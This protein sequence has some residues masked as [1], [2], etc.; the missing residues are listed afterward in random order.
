M[1]KIITGLRRCGKSF[2]L[3]RLYHDHLLSRGVA[4]DHILE[5]SLEDLTNVDLLDPRALLAHIRTQVRDVEKYYILLDEIQLVENFEGLLNSLLH[6]RNVEVFVT[7]SNSRFLSSDIVTGFRGRGYEIRLHPFCYREFLQAGYA[8]E[9]EAWDDFVNYGGIPVVLTGDTPEEKMELLNQLFRQV[10]VKDIRERH[11]LRHPGEFD[12]LLDLLASSV[13][14]LT[15]PL[16]L[17]RTFQS[18][19]QK[20]ISDLTL[21]SYLDHL[22]D[23]FLV[24]HAQRYDLR[25]KRYINSPMKYYFEDVGL[26]NARLGFRQQ[27]ENHL[28]ENILFNEL[29]VRGCKVDVGVVPIREVV[30]GK[31]VETKLEIDFVAYR[32]SKKYYLQSAFEMPNGDKA[33]QENRPL[34]A[35]RDSFKKIIVVKDNISVRRDEYGIATIGIRKFLQDPES[36]EV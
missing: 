10:Y 32:G 24:S 5:Y 22:E 31:H 2:L 30:D 9:D 27:E 28:M 12:E 16:K 17:S 29:K 33:A 23:A 11:K 20:R 21:R 8:S 18:V 26:R 13:G 3:F 36:L 15:S 19:K 1:V 7:G 14:S 4:P 6:F 34:L 25:G 35:I